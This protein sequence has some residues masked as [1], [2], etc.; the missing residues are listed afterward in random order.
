[1]I[2][3]VALLLI[4]LVALPAGADRDDPLLAGR[5]NG[6]KGYNTSLYSTNPTATVT[7]VNN[8]GSG[9][10]ALDLQVKA[11]PALAVN[12]KAWV[13]NLNAD[14]LD[15]RNAGAFATAGHDHGPNLGDLSCA[16][17]EVA[18]MGA[19][20][21]ECAAPVLVYQVTEFQSLGAGVDFT[22]TALCSAGDTVLGGGAQSDSSAH[23]PIYLA[24][25]TPIDQG[26]EGWRI[27]GETRTSSMIFVKAV[28]L[29]AP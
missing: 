25:S 3:L 23:D 8:R 24:R 20:G 28:C 14:L 29:D 7:L 13:A 5:A 18:K 19:S 11:G 26:Q 12:T 10:P 21:W 16:E 6:A 2:V 9:A 22:M 4:G 17:G 15:G 27:S 1:M